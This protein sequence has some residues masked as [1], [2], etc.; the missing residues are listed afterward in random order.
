M[1]GQR[2]AVLATILGAGVIA[3]SLVAVL[4]RSWHGSHKRPRVPVTILSGFLGAGKTTLLS[5]LLKNANGL[6]IAV[7]VND[8]AEVNVDARM[9]LAG[10]Q[11]SNLAAFSQLENG[12]LCCSTEADV[13]G[14]VTKLLEVGGEI[15]HVVIECSGMAQPSSLMELFAKAE[16][17]GNSYKDIAMLNQ[18]V[19]LVD[20][21]TLLKWLDVASGSTFVNIGDEAGSLAELLVEQIECADLIILSKVDCLQQAQLRK[22]C[23]AI[24]ALNSNAVLECASFGDVSPAVIFDSRKGRLSSLTKKKSHTHHDSHD[25]HDHEDGAEGQHAPHV[26]SFVYKSSRP[27]Q[28]QRLVVTLRSLRTQIEARVGK[29]GF[30]GDNKCLGRG[31]LRAK[32][33]VWLAT[34]MKRGREWAQVGETLHLHNGDLWSEEWTTMENGRG[35]LGGTGDSYG[36]RRQ[37]IVFIGT[38]EMQE[39]DIRNAL[40]YCL[41]TSE[42]MGCGPH[43]WQEFLDP[44]AITPTGPRHKRPST[45]GVGCTCCDPELKL[46]DQAVSRQIG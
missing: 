5:R 23:A 12:C 44:I 16:E 14:A 25:H 30:T 27:F 3:G 6:R 41:L 24:K 2:H 19:T 10:G 31:I 33:L 36:D 4:V 43:G 40:D 34:D 32:G 22:C 9:V 18:M 38:T 11:A 13:V 42:E 37:E 17:E 29:Q 15:D 1:D 45:H 8:L 39:A 46:I 21:R 7:L 20:G 26:R 35:E 28:P